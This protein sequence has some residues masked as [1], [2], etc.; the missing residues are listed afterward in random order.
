MPTF[1][2]IAYI[3]GFF[4]GEG[5]ITIPKRN[6]HIRKNPS[7]GLDVGFTNKDITTLHWI[8][9]LYGANLFEK[10][11]R[12]PNHSPAYELRIG[13]KKSVKS[14]LNDIA[15]FVRIKTKQ[16]ELALTFIGLPRVRMELVKLRGKRWP[17]LSG[18][19]IDLKTRE[20][21]KENLN[22]LNKRGVQCQQ[23]A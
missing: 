9:S 4:D 21:F 15:P 2:E 22:K 19:I 11:R 12:K 8:Q 7:Y 14:L 20:V 1:S 3:G 13:N 18:N 5:H 6:Q 16:V 17:L 10:R 23:S